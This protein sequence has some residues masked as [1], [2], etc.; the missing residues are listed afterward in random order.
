MGLNSSKARRKVTKVTPMPS[1]EREPKQPG[2][3]TVYSFQTPPSS[4]VSPPGRNPVLERQLPPLREMWYGRYPTV[5]RP[6]LLDHTR[7]GGGGGG[8]GGG[9]ASIIKQHPPRRLQKLEPFILAENSPADKY[10]NLP[11]GTVTRK[12]K[13]LER[14]GLAAK[15]PTGRRQYL[16]K[17]KMLEITKEAELKRRL[18]Q[19]ARLNKPKLRDLHL[20]G[21]FEHMQGTRSSDDE[22]LHCTEHDQIFNRSCGDLWHREFLKERGSPKSH[23]DQRDKVETWLLKQQATAESSSDASSNDSNN[24]KDDSD[25]FRKPYRRPALVRTKT[26]RI[27]LFDDFFDKE[28]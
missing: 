12:E 6:N 13:E 2:S 7:G 4:F 14:G 8:G 17:M 23:L 26:E 3:V 9:E 27:T 11:G 25:N 18:Q 1:K 16:L 22:E 19:E 5:P 10:L 24:W 21:T 20:L 28:L 15:H